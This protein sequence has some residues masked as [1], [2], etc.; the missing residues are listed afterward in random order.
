MLR[1]ARKYSRFLHCPTQ[2]HVFLISPQKDEFKHRSFDFCGEAGVELDTSNH[3]PTISAMFSDLR[4]LE[5]FL[6]F[7]ALL[8][9]RQNRYYLLGGRSGRV[10]TRLQLL[11]RY[12]RGVSVNSD[13]SDH[14][15]TPSISIPKLAVAT[16]KRSIRN[17][18]RQ[19]PMVAR[20]LE[21]IER[22]HTRMWAQLGP[23]NSLSRWAKWCVLLGEM[24]CWAVAPRLPGALPP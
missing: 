1:L 14:L 10:C 2:R 17:P 24:V 15:W 7:S 20:P 22:A 18:H 19:C 3:L 12:F 11:T 21:P 8:Q 23:G 6:I 4:R 9:R 16:G 13:F 5:I